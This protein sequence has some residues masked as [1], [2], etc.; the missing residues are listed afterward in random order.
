MKEDFTLSNL[1]KYG[2]LKDYLKSKILE[3]KIS[4]IELNED[5]IFGAKD[6]YMKFFKLKDD[7]SLENHRL[8]NLMSIENL[9]YRMTLQI[10]VQKYCDK[11]FGNIINK[12]YYEN[13]EDSDSVTYSFLRVKDYGLIKELYYRIK[14][15][16][17]DFKKL[18]RKYT[19]GVEKK[20]SGLIGPLLL[21][22]VHPIVREKLKKSNLKLINKPFKVKNEWIICKLEEYFESKLDKKRINAIK[23]EML[24]KEIEK[25]LLRNYKERLN[26]FV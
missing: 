12:H 8:S 22:K 14:D 13:K 2:L 25:E 19:L 5:E 6:F 15:D 4:K 9:F 16:K 1:S 10:K 23:S 7:S 18:A 11:H 24:D 21:K 20:T 3:E 17:V 26:S